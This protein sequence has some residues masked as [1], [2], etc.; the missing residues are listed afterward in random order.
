VTGFRRVTG[1]AF[2]LCGV[3]CA[4]SPME[5]LAV[6]RQGSQVMAPLT[7]RRPRRSSWAPCAMRPDTSVVWVGGTKYLEI[8]YQCF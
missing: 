7:E 5:P 8:V 6:A 4:A 3:S 1:L 2:A